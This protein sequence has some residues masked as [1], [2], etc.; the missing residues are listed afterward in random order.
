MGLRER[1]RRRRRGRG[2]RAGRASA[3]AVGGK[4]VVAH[5]GSDGN[6]YTQTFDGAWQKAVSV[7]GAA[8]KGIRPQV[9][10]L[11]DTDAMVI[12]ARDG[13]QKLA[14]TTRT[15][16][17]WSAPVAID[18]TAYTKDPFTAAALSGGRVLLAWHGVDTQKAPSYFA[19]YSGGAWGKPAPLLANNNPITV[20]AP[21]VAAGVCG[22]D[23]LAVYL[24][25]D[26]KVQ[27]VR[28]LGTTWSAP[29]I[30]PGA[31]AVTGAAVAAAP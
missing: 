29:E 17:A 7:A 9:V 6:I 3:A 10:A 8:D 4:L 13:D 11:G 16:S 28:L 30:V 31:S 20:G 1:F 22:A 19:V 12:Y 26:A 24:G 5:G 27:L 15:G 25:E 23:A 2:V 21:Q 18:P 14:F